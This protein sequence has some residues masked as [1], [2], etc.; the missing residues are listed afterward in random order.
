MET[1]SGLSSFIPKEEMVGN[2]RYLTPPLYGTKTWADIYTPRQLL[3][4]AILAK[5]I[6]E[7]KNPSVKLIMALTVSKFADR[8]SSMCIWSPSTEWFLRC[9]G[10]QTIQMTWDFYEPRPYGKLGSNWNTTFINV[11]RGINAARVP[12]GAP[13]GHSNFADAQNHPMLD[14][15]IDLWATDP[16]YYDSVPYADISNY[17]V[18]WLKRMLPEITLE[19]GYAPREKEVVMDGTLTKSGEIKN[20]DWYEDHVGA[21]LKEGRRVTKDNGIAYWIYAHK[22]T[23]GWST[24]LK[25]II[26]AGWKV[27]G[28]WPIS[29]ER[30]TRLRAQRS[31][32]L[33]TSVH[34]VMRPREENAGIGDWADI[35]GELPGRINSWLQRLTSDGI[36]GADAIFACIGPAMELYSRWNRVEKADG[37][38]VP[39]DDYLKIVWDTVATEAMKI[40]DPTISNSN[41]EDDA[42]FSMMVLW[43]L[44]QSQGAF[45][46]HELHELESSKKESK[47]NSSDIPFDTASLLAR[48]IG[49]DIDKLKDQNIIEMKKKQNKKF[50]CL[51]S[52][53]ERR[54]YLLGISNGN[55]KAEIMDEKGVQ[56]KLGED[57][58]AAKMR[59]KNEKVQK[60]FVEIPRR[61]S[62]LDQLHQAM[63][64]HSDGNTAALDNL[65]KDV[66]GNNQMSWKLAQTFNTL[67]PEG[68]W[69]RSKIEGVID[70]Y[71]SIFKKM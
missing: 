71:K 18:V 1:E 42:R 17:F 49:S 64:L 39:I 12:D 24:V 37:T 22:S 8:N 32:A 7:I 44:R 33:E 28:S 27:T 14:D 2:S 62:V 5:E 47:P 63:L 11:V 65:I 53:A 3:T 45:D 55:P 48:G 66:I 46:E 13:E 67:Y 69:E 52:P 51:L 6:S 20:A 61:E 19:N 34:I 16:P 59:Q 58:T 25:G 10:I 40:I 21:A 43:T 60:V 26:N 41:V 30:A 38:D 4:Q 68:S 31:A 35:L 9:F 36:Y 54:H 70:R 50:V 57:L 56:L 23:E 29:T 15:Q